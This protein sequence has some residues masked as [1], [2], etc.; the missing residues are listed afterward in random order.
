[1]FLVLERACVPLLL[2][3]MLYKGRFHPVGWPLCVGVILCLDLSAVEKRI[4]T[5]LNI[6]LD[7]IYLFFHTVS[8]SFRIC[9]LLLDT[10]T[11]MVRP[12]GVPAFL[13]P[14]CDFLW[15]WYFPSFEVYLVFVDIFTIFFSQNLHD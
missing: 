5:A 2:G 3:G 11:F 15:S 13:S 8:C 4:L 1:M 6:T 12:F 10:N 9:E 14:C 7:L